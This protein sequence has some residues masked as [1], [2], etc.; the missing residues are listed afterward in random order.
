M[1][2]D[3][4]LEKA[5]QAASSLAYADLREMRQYVDE[6]LE[7]RKQEQIERLRLEAEAL[8]IDLRALARTPSRASSRRTTGGGG[9]ARFWYR[10]PDNPELIWRGKGKRPRWLQEMIDRGDDISGLQVEAEE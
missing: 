3:N 8:G 2:S 6:L 4:L 5:K 7:E 1:P 10:H 9:K